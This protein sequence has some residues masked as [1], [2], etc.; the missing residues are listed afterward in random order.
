MINKIKNNVWQLCFRLFGSC[1]YLIKL[2]KNNILIDTGSSLN[3]DELTEDLKK[4]NIKFS[5]INIVLL[6][7]NHFDHT[8][9]LDFFKDAKIYGSKLEFPNKEISDI[10]EL[11]INEFEIIDT[12]GHSK[13]SFCILYQDVLFSGD[14]IFH[15]NGIGRM[16]LEG[17]SELDMAKSLEKLKR[18]NYKILCPGHL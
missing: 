15:N 11:N 8:D 13:G 14:T 12:S 18:I 10:H 17:G 2:E 7:H 6:T 4:L 1:V 5:E 3:R 16:D 9:N